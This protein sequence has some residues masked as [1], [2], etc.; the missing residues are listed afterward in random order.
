MAHMSQSNY[1]YYSYYTEILVRFIDD[2]ISH[3][4]RKHSLL[5]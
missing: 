4:G 1:Y 3:I 2:F 5:V